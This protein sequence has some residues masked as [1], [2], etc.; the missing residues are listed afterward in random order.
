M[1]SK[2][3][4]WRKNPASVFYLAIPL[5]VFGFGCAGLVAYLHWKMN[6]DLVYA[7]IFIAGTILL[8]IGLWHPI[9]YLLN[10]FEVK[11]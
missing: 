11:K 5:A 8:V 7:G 10:P 1:I 6:G 9:K 3:F 4:N 2:M